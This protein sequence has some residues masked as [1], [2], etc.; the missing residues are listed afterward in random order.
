MPLQAI[1]CCELST[2]PRRK[3]EQM[4]AG[5]KPK[6]TRL[7]VIQGTYRSD[8]ANPNEPKPRAAIPDC[9]EFL[10]GQARKQ[11]QQTAKKLVRIGLMTQLDDMALSMLCQG[12]QE[13]L[14]ATEQVRK[15][16][17]R[18]K[19]PNGFPVLISD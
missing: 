13:Y 7:K 1:I 11:Y 18:V 5:R 8:R 14:E 16:G 19:S 3:L 2:K 9:P 17:I 6:P 10:K 15:S 4:T 12:W